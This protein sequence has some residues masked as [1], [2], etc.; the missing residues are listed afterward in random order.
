M[1]LIIYILSLFDRY[2]Q[3]KIIDFFKNRN[4]QIKIFF[5]VGAH[6]GETIKLF[7]KNL[8]IQNFYCFE[9][10]PVNFFFL[11]KKITKMNLK[12]NIFNFALGEK[13]S[14]LTLNQEDESSSSTL[15]EINK[16]S[17][18]YKKKNKILNIF[19]SSKNNLK[20]INVE[21][22]CLNDIMKEK[23]IERI[24]ILKTDTEGFEL[25][26][27]KG[28]REKI[29]NIKYI[30]FE[31]HFDDMLVKKY[32]LSDIHNYLIKNGFQK[33]LKVKMFFRKSFEY[34]YENMTI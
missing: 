28:A 14:E 6:R 33:K 2:N 10:S 7:K 34:I 20:K 16:E 26:V 29:K 23:F 15:N 30:Y 17:N 25:F 1:K 11:K 24:D 31:H 3:K 9:P 32:T 22:K 27:L 19:G 12:I 4:F 8:K 21:V 13:Q 5:D 18:Y